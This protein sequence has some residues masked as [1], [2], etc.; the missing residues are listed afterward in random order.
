MEGGCWKK[1]N[2]GFM[3]IPLMVRDNTIIAVGSNDTKP[4]YDFAE[5]VSLQVFNLE[6]GKSASATVLSMKGEPELEV[7]LSR[8]GNTVEVRSS[9]VG[10][11]WSL[12][13]KGI[14][15]LDSVSGGSWKKEGGGVAVTLDNSEALLR[16]ML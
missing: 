8:K 16:I 14:L 7:G 13:F 15:E 5:G 2:H 12:L 11:P 4:D 3:S 1:E 10:K 6:D 9:G